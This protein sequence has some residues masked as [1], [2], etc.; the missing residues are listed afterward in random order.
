V[1]E[2]NAALDRDRLWLE[3]LAEARSRLHLL[4]QEQLSDLNKLVVLL[5]P[6]APARPWQ[7]VLEVG[8]LIRAEQARR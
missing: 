5:D 1:S 4:T 8:V 7:I 3:Q 2:L 6:Y